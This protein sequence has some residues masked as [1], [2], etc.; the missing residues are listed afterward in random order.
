MLNQTL[1]LTEEL[2]KPEEKIRQQL[3]ELAFEKKKN[4][5]ILQGYAE[6]VIVFD[7]GGIISFFNKSAEKVFMKEAG[8]VCGSHISELLD[9]DF[10][11][12][13]KELVPCVKIDGTESECTTRTEVMV[14]VADGLPMR[15]SV[16]K[17]KVGGESY[18][19]AFI[20][21]ESVEQL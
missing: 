17:G 6:G 18:F 9:I 11:E 21:N 1:E 10:I 2:K 20:Q 12:K 8:K 13:N 14:K 4:E 3:N 15:L 16:A 19:T 7:Q 5:L